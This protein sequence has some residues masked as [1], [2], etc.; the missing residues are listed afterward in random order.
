MTQRA[1]GSQT[2]VF[3]GGGPRTVGILERLAANTADIPGSARLSVHIVDPFPAGGGRI[4]RAE[5][6][7]L[8]WMNSMA[9]DVTIFTDSSVSCE[10][11]IVPGPTLAEWIVGEGRTTLAA[12]GLADRAVGLRPDDFAGRQIQAHYLRWAHNRAVASLPDRITVTEHAASAVAVREDRAAQRVL[13]AD[14][15]ELQADVVVLAQGYLDRD[16]TPEERR[17]AAAAEPHGLTYIPPGYTADVDLSDLRPGEPV[18]VRGFGLAFIDLM[19][20]LGEGRGGRF[21]RAADGELRYHPSGVEPVLHVGS[22]RGVPYHAKLGYSLSDSTPV[23]ARYFTTEAVAALGAD[24]RPTDFRHKIWPLM[25]KEL[26]AAHYRQLFAAH[27]DRTLVSWSE[28][29]AIL[30]AA[31]VNSTAFADAVDRAVPSAR[32]DSSCSAS[33]SHWPVG[34]SDPG[35]TSPMPSS[36]TSRVTCV[37]ART[38]TSPRTRPFSMRC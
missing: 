13:L 21:E 25:A 22:R 11:P 32:T 20:L 19:V 6:S 9:R 34:F 37:D 24:G 16:A 35:R 15:S 5:Q 8:L 28:F 31:D 12:A 3:V 17:L 18:L 4:W 7:P 23:P 10:G 27:P 2:L 30:D 26:T 33:T 36:G 1:G 38:R 29:S 14:G